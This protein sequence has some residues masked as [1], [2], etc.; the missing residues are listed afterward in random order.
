M[1]P[2]ALGPLVAEHGQVSGLAGVPFVLRLVTASGTATYSFFN[3]S[4]PRGLR[5]LDFWCYAAAAGGAADT[6]TLKNGS[7]NIS[8]ALDLN[9]ADN[10]RVAT[11]TLDD[12]YIDVEKNGTLSIS[13]AS[14][15]VARAHVLCVWKD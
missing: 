15:A 13:T 4:C 1:P 6:V 12:A 7:N 9:V 8:N 2:R 14:D 3:G 5:V 10:T 11:T